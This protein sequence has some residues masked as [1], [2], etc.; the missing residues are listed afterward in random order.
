MASLRQAPPDTNE[1]EYEAPIESDFS[2]LVRVSDFERYLGDAIY[3]GLLKEQHQVRHI[4]FHERS[5]LDKN[6]FIQVSRVFF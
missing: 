3:F 2:K 6:G 5:K 4:I 1:V